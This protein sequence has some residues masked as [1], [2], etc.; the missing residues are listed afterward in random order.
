MSIKIAAKL[1]TNVHI[2]KN[3]EVNPAK[4]KPLNFPVLIKFIIKTDPK[5]TAITKNTPAID[6]KNLKGK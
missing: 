5:N 3:A 4:R 6:M 2:K 1:N